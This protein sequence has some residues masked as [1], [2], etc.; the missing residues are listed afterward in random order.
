MASPAKITPAQKQAL[1]TYL[2][3]N[4][5]C[6]QIARTEFYQYPSFIAIYNNYFGDSD[7]LFAKLIS[8]EITIGEANRQRSSLNAKAQ[9]EGN[10]AS[11]KLFNQYNAAINQEV[12]AAQA[13]AAQR[14]AIAAQYLM[15]QQ[16]INAQQQMNTR[17][18]INNNLILNTTCNRLGDQVNCI[19]Q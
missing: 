17:N 8:R 1:L 9:S 5:K 7:V 12:Q 14:R 13:D 4:Q 6:R 10:Q 11:E 15:N 18:Q 16:N 3:A 2:A 19:T